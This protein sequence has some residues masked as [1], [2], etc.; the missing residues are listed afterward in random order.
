MSDR[1]SPFLIRFCFL[2]GSL[3]SSY[4][5]LIHLGNYDQSQVN[6]TK[7]IYINKTCK[8]ELEGSNT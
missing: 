4:S 6:E 7:I 1:T 2:I 5:V 8:L 3:Y